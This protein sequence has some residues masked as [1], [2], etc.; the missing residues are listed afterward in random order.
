MKPSS[1]AAT[2]VLH[3]EQKGS[4]ISSTSEWNALKEHVKD[5]NS[6]I[7][8]HIKMLLQTTFVILISLTQNL[9]NFVQQDQVIL[10]L[11]PSLWD[12]YETNEAVLSLAVYVQ[13]IS[14]V[15]A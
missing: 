12:C 9:K 2:A 7:D 1:K 3:T 4:L 10:L 11:H 5:T 14:F 15:F 13:N 8:R 6:V